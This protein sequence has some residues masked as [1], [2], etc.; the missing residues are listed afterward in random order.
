M[1]NSLIHDDTSCW[2]WN[3]DCSVGLLRCNRRSTGESR[4]SST[5]TYYPPTTTATTTTT[6]TAT[7]TTTT[8]PVTTIDVYGGGGRGNTTLPLHNYLH[9]RITYTPLTF[10]FRYYPRLL[11]PEWKSATQGRTRPE[12]KLVGYLWQCLNWCKKKRDLKG[13]IR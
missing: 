7:T 11:Y 6:T 2:K 9:S 4:T 1:P 12:I 8:Q 13:M 3:S 5:T 10:R